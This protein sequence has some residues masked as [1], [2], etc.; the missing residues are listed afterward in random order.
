M[1]VVIA[2]D[3]F[4]GS[5]TTF[6]AASAVERGLRYYR[7]DIDTVKVPIADGGEGTVD[8]LVKALNGR[9]VE[10]NVLNPVGK[11]V[12]AKY[13]ILP[14]DIAVI[15]MATASGL[16]LITKEK[17]NPLITTTYGTGELI[18]NAMDQGCKKIY[19][20]LGGSATN[21]AGAGMAQ[22]IGVSFKDKDN[23]EIGFGGGELINVET[24]DTSAIDARVKNTDIVMLSDVTNPLC[25]KNG[26]SAVYG[27]QKGASGRTIEI[28]DRN[29]EH[30]GEFIKEQVSIDVLEIP[31]S[32]AAG[33]LAAGLFAFCSAK[34][35]SGVE[36]V[37]DII[38]LEKHLQDADLVITGEGRIDFQTINGK[39]PIGVARTAKK[40]GIPVIAIVGSIGEGA[41]VVY[42][43]G[44]DAI[45]DIVSEPISLDKALEEGISLIEKT[46]ER[47][48]RIWDTSENSRIS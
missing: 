16:A 48:M 28:L 19:I 23:Q 38:G 32:G 43:Y 21:D 3:S 26:A 14:G 40:Y 10:A 27:P 15:E 8:I 46:A 30:F 45:I 1:K 33:G 37:I 13:G 22:A 12:N 17:Y 5:C 24:I 44:I 4:K 9:Y 25:G 42:N 34:C 7:D 29:L 2:I 11:K 31:G 20:G 18:K 36:K 6:E 47:T 39:V 41:E 35:H